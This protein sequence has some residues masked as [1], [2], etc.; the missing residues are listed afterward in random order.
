M[1]SIAGRVCHAEIDQLKV[2]CKIPAAR[3]RIKHDALLTC[4]RFGD[5]D[6]KG[7]GRVLKERALEQRIESEMKQH[8]S[9]L[10][11]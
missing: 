9:I 3:R 10:A 1:G 6:C 7:D 4:N 11:D 5:G 8:S 2:Y